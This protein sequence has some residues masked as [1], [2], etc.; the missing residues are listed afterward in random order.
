MKITTPIVSVA[1]LAEHLGQPALVVLDASM[2]PAI[3][4]ASS[5][6]GHEQLQI[7]GSRSF[8]LKGDFSDAASELPN[9]MPTPEAFAKA[10]R[11]LGIDSSS[12][13]VVYDRKGVYSSPRAWWMFRAM[14]HTQVAVLDGGFPGWL[15]SSR[16][17]EARLS[18]SD[19][20]S[21]SPASHADAEPGDFVARPRLASFC[22]ATVV[23]QALADKERVV[24]DARAPD[25][26][27]GRAEEPRA[28]MRTG[29]MPGARNLPWSQVQ[30]SGHMRS[31]QELRAIF[32]ALRAMDKQLVLSCGSGVTACVLAL[33]AALAGHSDLRVYDGSW[34]EW[35][36][37]DAPFPV[38]SS[39]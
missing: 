25:R 32:D 24:L 30:E 11:K 3:D 27:F 17:T 18:A 33:A 1:W 34:S 21:P 37:P 6:A 20:A 36:A 12:V 35:G 29:H 28:G 15:R 26:F 22:D 39:E 4:K 5:E 10:A 19:G 9:M 38:A 8:D 7:P 31:K 13:I 14:G 16:P 2:D 23:S